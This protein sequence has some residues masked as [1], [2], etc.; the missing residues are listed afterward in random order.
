M[1]MEKQLSQ[2]SLTNYFFIFLLVS[3]IILLIISFFTGEN[4][5][6]FSGIRQISA[7]ALLIGIGEWINHP[8]Q[9]TTALK[10]NKGQHGR[11]KGKERL[12]FHK[13]LHRKRRPSS[14]GS[15]F[16]ISGLLLL[17]TGLADYL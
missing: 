13:I 12:V 9:K 17:F 4:N 8:L 15:L 6:V 10:D 14:L 11:N 3:G 5:Q 16:E 7:G 2:S 1:A